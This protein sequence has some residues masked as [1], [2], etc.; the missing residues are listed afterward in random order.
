M[1]ISNTFED[2]PLSDG[3]SVFPSC[4]LCTAMMHWFSNQTWRL[5]HSPWGICQCSQSLD[6]DNHTA[7]KVFFSSKIYLNIIS[8]LTFWTKNGVLTQCVKY[9]K[10]MASMIAADTEGYII[11]RSLI[12]L[13]TNGYFLRLSAYNLSRYVTLG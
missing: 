9:D 6:K 10:Q 2:I 3:L 1:P 7:A 8:K 4:S 5:H 11:R 12:G 13:L